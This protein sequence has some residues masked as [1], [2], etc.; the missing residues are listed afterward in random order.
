MP[1][2]FCGVDV[3]N[4]DVV[5]VEFVMLMLLQTTLVLEQRNGSFRVSNLINRN[6]TAILNLILHST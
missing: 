2:E 3:V 5:D 1:V 6:T 4:L